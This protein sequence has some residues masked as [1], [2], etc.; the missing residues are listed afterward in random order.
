[1]PLV[2]DI[3]K[4]RENSIASLD[5]SHDYFTHTQAAW[6][7]VQQFV[8]EGNKATIHNQETG[9]VVQETDLPCLAQ[10]YITG[11]LTEATFQHFVS[12]FEDFMGNFLCLWLNHF[13]QS[14]SGKQIDFNTVLQCSDKA[15]IVR[16]MVEKQ[17]NE[18]QYKRV[19]EWFEYMEKLANLGCPSPDEIERIAEIKATRDILVH[20][21]GIANAVYVEKSAGHARFAVGERVEVSEHYHRQSWQLVKQV[22][23]DVAKA[24]CAKLQR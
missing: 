7:I 13:P 6:R 24:G 8:R 1:M 10:Q 5:A 19:K 21:R 18:L 9:S 23:T 22:V 11:Y 3:E 20:N 14:L 17:V 15:D 16:V 12:L 4:L 2:D